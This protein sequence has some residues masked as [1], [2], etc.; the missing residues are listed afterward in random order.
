MREP[1]ARLPMIAC[2]AISGLLF[3]QASALAQSVEKTD[4]VP[5]LATPLPVY[6]GG[7]VVETDAGWMRQWPGTYVET[8]FVG[9]EAFVEI[10]EG[11]VMLDITVDGSEPVQLIKPA[12]GIYRIGGLKDGAHSLKIQVISESQ[13]GATAIGG[14]YTTG[15]FASLK[16][17]GPQI[18]FIGD[19]HTVGY[20][21][22]STTRECTEEDVWL[23]TD[24][25]QGPA[26]V[27]ADHYG[28]DYQVNAI[29]GRGIVRNYDGFPGDTLP[30]AYPYVLLN[31]DRTYE[32]EGWTPEVVVI[33]LGTND[34][35]T[36]LKPEEKWESREALQ[37]DFVSTYI[38]FIEMLHQRYVDASFVLWAT[39]LSE[40]EIAAMGEEV[41]A[42]VAAGGEID[43]AFIPVPGLAMSGCHYHPDTA[44]ARRIADLVIAEIGTLNTETE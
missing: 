11:D 30:E 32:P 36:D 39:D 7:R 38:S 21:N 14:V 15:E 13:A 12:A 35:S 8:A 33:S 22:T 16:P 10:G 37:Q 43:I 41:A 23:T 28:A 17:R 18:E 29:S 5:D 6:I 27:I 34:F 26:A 42:N 40:G 3:T 19:S 4:A 1:F 25:A 20:G 2:M 9:G 31:D 44:D 24:T